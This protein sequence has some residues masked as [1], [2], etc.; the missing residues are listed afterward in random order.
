[1]TVCVTVLETTVEVEISK[2][3]SGTWSAAG[4]YLGKRIE[5]TAESRSAVIDRWR[6]TAEYRGR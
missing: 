2:Q 6:R 4:T 5:V 1:V 3:N